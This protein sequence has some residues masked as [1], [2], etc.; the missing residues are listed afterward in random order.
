MFLGVAVLVIISSCAENQDIP[1]PKDYPILITNEAINVD[2]TGVTISAR[3]I[4]GNSSE[5]IAF[6]FRWFSAHETFDYQITPLS[7]DMMTLRIEGGLSVDTSYSFSAYVKTPQYEIVSEHKSFTSAGSPKLEIFDFQPKM[8]DVGDTV[9]IFGKG[10]SPGKTSIFFQ[11]VY[12]QIIQLSFTSIKF[13]VP[14]SQYVGPTTFKIL[15]RGSSAASPEKITVNGHNITSISPI[16]GIIGETVISLTGHGFAATLEENIVHVGN[17]GSATILQADSNSISFIMPYAMTPGNAPVSLEVNGLTFTTDETIEAVSRWGKLNDFPG[18]PRTGGNLVTTEDAAFYIGGYGSGT[19]SN[20]FE[21]VW[22]YNSTNDE[23]TKMANFP[24][25]T[26]LDA[27][28]FVINGLIYRTAR[29]GN[30]RDYWIYSPEANEWK[31]FPVAVNQYFSTGGSGTLVVDDHAYI[32]GG[33]ESNR[34]D[35]KVY[36]ISVNEWYLKINPLPFPLD[37]RDALFVASNKGY[38]IPFTFGGSMPKM[39]LFDPNTS[40]F[41]TTPITTVPFQKSYQT[42]NP[43]TFVVNG[44]LYLGD[45]SANNEVLMYRYSF[46]SNLWTRIENFPGR[47]AYNK[48]SFQIGNK[49][50]V[51]FI[52]PLNPIFGSTLT[53]IWMY[54]IEVK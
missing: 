5:I 33:T 31:Q 24:G 26:R 2:S 48:S 6:G 54:D 32:L 3:L 37:S 34:Y 23:W 52:A 19:N 22:R 43:I 44:D 17:S 40:D 39:Y 38:A 42:N 25:D 53:D 51:G 35:I 9:T 45:Y 14:K 27:T 15:S 10:F 4:P 18:E 30:Y 8:V 7:D 50:Y 20:Y 46:A 47:P 28:S 13:I 36:D 29:S 11:G 41:D 1:L 12:G 49:G 16:R 21:E